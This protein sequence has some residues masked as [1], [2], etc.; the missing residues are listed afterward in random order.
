M[1]KINISHTD[2]CLY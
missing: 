1:R 2:S